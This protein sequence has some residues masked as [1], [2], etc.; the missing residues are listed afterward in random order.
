MGRHDAVGTLTNIAHLAET[1]V[2]WHASTV[3]L[4][5]ITGW[6]DIERSLNYAA[7]NGA[8]TMR[9]LLP[10]FSGLAPMD[11]EALSVIP[12]E[13]HKRL[14]SWRNSYPLMPITLEPALPRN[15][16]ATV[17]GVLADSPS[18]NLIVSGDEILAINDDKPFSRVD[19]F[20]TLHRLANPRLLLN[21]EGKEITVT[22]T[23]AARSSS[24][25]VMDR[26]LD[27]RDLDRAI[28]MS[29]EAENVLLLTSQWAEPLWAK[30]VPDIWQVV[31]VKSNSF[32]GNIAAA[33]LLTVED[34]RLVLAS[35]DLGKYQRILLPP[36]S[37]DESGLDLMGED[38]RALARE[39]P[40]PLVWS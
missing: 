31:A 1:G 17:A 36:V 15:L 38:C 7:Q 13:A 30:V 27:S 32:G 10:G 35:T 18:A 34:Y 9:L 19:G 20:Y 25:V 2:P 28:A 24:G 29:F 3:M 14:W 39:I 8:K 22:L 40:I 21:R 26:D 37:F 4:P 11:W 12:Q 5:H 16:R 33:G 23:K 6:A